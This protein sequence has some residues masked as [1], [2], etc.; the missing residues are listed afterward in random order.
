MRLRTIAWA[1]VA[2]LVVAAIVHEPPL[3]FATLAASAIAALVVVSRRR[4]FDAVEFER[5]VSRRVVPWGGELEV[6]FGITNDKLLPLVWV[7]VRDQWPLGLVPS[8]FDL[9]QIALL[10]RQE[11]LQTVSVRWYERLR[12]HYRVT[13]EARGVHRFGPVE[14]DAGDPFGVASVRRQ[15]ESRDEIVVLPRVL[16]TQGFEALVGRPLVEQAAARSLATDPTAL[17]GARPYRAGDSVRAID[18]RATARTATLHT[19]EFDPTSL[20]AVRLLLDASSL[21]RAWEPIDPALMEL[22]CVVGAS[23]A[24]AFSVR[25]YAVGLATNAVTTGERHA[26]DFPTAHG[27][28]PEVLEGLAGLRPHTYRDFGGVLAAELRDEGAE[29]DRVLLT[30]RLRPA[31]RA[32]LGQLRAERPTLVVF[33]GRPDEDEAA[34]VD[35]VVPAD[36][37]W[38]RVDALQLRA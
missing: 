8:G 28:L 9:R 11:L 33:V 19:K 23:L 32:V 24:A 31:V 5:T 26:L 38:R 2:G 27:A 18:W 36:L 10:G 15:L 14:L 13:C 34:D 20:A 17:R 29:A 4:L 25:G 7:R 16:D 1:C 30:A 12:R 21:H 35:L 6:T 3:A 37:D 22:L